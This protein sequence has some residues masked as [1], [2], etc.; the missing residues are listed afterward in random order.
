MKIYKTIIREPGG[1]MT[2]PLFIGMALNHVF[3]QSDDEENSAA[4][5][6]GRGTSHSQ[7]RCA[8]PEAADI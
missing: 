4:R 2:V 8:S 6:Y 5:T 7:A 3:S 1:L